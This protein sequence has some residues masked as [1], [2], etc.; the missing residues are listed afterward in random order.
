MKLL[1]TADLH[2]DSPFAGKRPEEAEARREQQR[3]V[4]RR[5]FDLAQREACDLILIAG[6]LFDGK[7]VTPETERLCLRLFSEAGI[8]V[9]ISPGNHDPYVEGSF[10]QKH[11]LPENVY[12]FSSSQLQCFEIEELRVKLFGYA[13][14]SS[15]LS[16]S[17]LA[18]AAPYEEDGMLRILCAHGDLG[19]AISRYAPVLPADAARLGMDYCALGHVHKAGEV[20]R[21]EETFLCY[22]GI[23]QGRSYDETGKGSV[24]LVTLEPHRLPEIRQVA[25]S[26]EEYRWEELDL[27]GCEDAASLSERIR[28][29]VARVAGEGGTHLRLTL[30]G[31]VPTESMEELL[32]KEESLLGD[33]AEL[34]LKDRTVPFVEGAYLEKDVGLKGAFYR[35]LYPKLIHEDPHVR[36]QA[37]RALQI[38]L[39]A[40]ENRRIPGEEQ[41]R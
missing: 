37:L 31:T 35:S 14:S 38:G 21:E 9:V 39:S 22:A 30:T 11:T 25:V 4:L 5:I 27:G 29:A 7:Y 18:G 20:V 19:T 32:A 13:F 6:D 28:T 24:R 1:H 33:L 26:T 8:P 3:A 2:L 12:V 40:I 17:P 36:R 41:G 10:Y 15:V 23:P 34:E 16:E